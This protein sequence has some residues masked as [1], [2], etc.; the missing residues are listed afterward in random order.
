M[1]SEKEV[2]AIGKCWPLLGRKLDFGELKQSLVNSVMQNL[3]AHPQLSNM[4]GKKIPE[5][6][7][8]NLNLD[9]LPSSEIAE[10]TGM[11]SVPS[12]WPV[13]SMT[14]RPMYTFVIM[15]MSVESIQI[16]LD[17]LPWYELVKPLS[18]QLERA[19]ANWPG[20]KQGK[21]LML[22]IRQQ[23]GLTAIRVKGMLSLMNFEEILTYPTYSDGSTG[24]R[25]LWKSKEAQCLWLP[26][27][28][29]FVPTSPSENG[30]L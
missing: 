19:K 12:P 29:G 5:L 18:V 27:N 26:P 15:E 22:R 10:L 8:L 9:D 1:K 23:S 21:T 13:P 17:L 20:N 14:S 24:T 25:S 6:M 2:S 7:D 3:L 4:S 11:L 30:T 16:M 28:S